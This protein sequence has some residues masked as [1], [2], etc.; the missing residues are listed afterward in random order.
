MSNTVNDKQQ[1]KP[2]NVQCNSGR[3]DELLGDIFVHGMVYR[4][5]NERFGTQDLLCLKVP[6][7][8]GGKHRFFPL[9]RDGYKIS[10]AQGLYFSSVK[11][12][13]VLQ[14]WT[15]REYFLA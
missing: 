3:V 6:D 12:D 15:L 2:P 5:R 14:I 13:H 1:S 8:S 9:L 11:D 7:I 4:A 10:P